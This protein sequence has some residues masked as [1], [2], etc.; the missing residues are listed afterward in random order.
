MK[1]ARK[2]IVASRPIKAGELFREE[3]ITCKRPG[4]GISPMK[5]DEILGKKAQRDYQP[6]EKL[7]ERELSRA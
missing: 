4:D 6:D 1:I 7:D 2:S 3:N 5:W